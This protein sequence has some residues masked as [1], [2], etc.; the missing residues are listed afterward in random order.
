M[1]QETERTFVEQAHDFS[2]EMADKVEAVI[3]WILQQQEA[4]WRGLL[5]WRA[6][7]SLCESPAE[8]LLDLWFSAVYRER[9]PGDD[10][11]F[12]FDLRSQAEVTANGHQYRL[13][14][15]LDPHDPSL[16]QPR[17]GA[18]SYPK[19]AVEIDGHAFHEKT[20]EQVTYRNRRDRDLQLAGWTVLHFSGS[21]LFRD[22]LRVAEDVY[23]TLRRAHSQ[24]VYTLAELNARITNRA[25][26]A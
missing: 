2:R 10:K 26:N 15:I 12:G 5:V 22:P 13:D 6:S 7:R 24:Y 18:S 14:F 16:L 11:M 4:A 20:K 8:A 21:E 3:Q 9:E 1:A 25:T 17:D 23:H 19:I